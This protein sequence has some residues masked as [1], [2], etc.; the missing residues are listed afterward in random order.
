MCSVVLVSVGLQASIVD[1]LAPIA[2][3]ARWTVRD[4]APA[5]VD[6]LTAIGTKFGSSGVI[7][8]VSE[9]LFV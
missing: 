5:N 7:G 8:V 1:F 3:L 9:V 6:S 4:I 2:F